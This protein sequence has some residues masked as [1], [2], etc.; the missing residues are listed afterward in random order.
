M[1]LITKHDIMSLFHQA[2]TG[3]VFGGEKTV[4]ESQPVSRLQV[5]LKLPP[6]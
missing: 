1:V 6:Q 2:E 4:M 5:L 3:G